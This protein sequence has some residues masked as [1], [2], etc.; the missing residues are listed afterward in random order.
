M[1]VDNVASQMTLQNNNVREARKD[2][3]KDDFLKLLVTQLQN[4]DPLSPME[5]TDFIAQMAQFSAL[6]EMSALNKSF[7]FGSSVSLIGKEVIAKYGNDLIQGVVERVSV[8]S[9]QSWLTVG[10]YMF[11]LSDVVE[12][13]Y[14][15]N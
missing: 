2:L 15:S 13:V 7:E 3:G 5:D 9:G 4:Q 12:V 11:Q 8:Q 6:E 10:E 14:D 1:K